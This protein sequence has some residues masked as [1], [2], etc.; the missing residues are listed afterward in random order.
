[1]KRG[2]ISLCM[3]LITGFATMAMAQE[4]K[5][6]VA[7]RTPERTAVISE[8]A[9]RAPYFLFFD[10]KGHLLEAMQ[11]PSA[12]N[13]GGAGGDTADLLKKKKVTLFVAGR[14]GQKM[15]RALKHYKIEISEQTG[16][17]H[18]VVQAIIQKQ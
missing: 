7:C 10:N 18:D 12:G 2:L 13:V 8:V 11:N 17:A 15:K 6:G 9:G 16:V 14:V 3:M 5:I 4:T 1:M